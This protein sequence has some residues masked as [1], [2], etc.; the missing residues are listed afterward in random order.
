MK[1]NTIS[2]SSLLLASTTVAG[3]A[4]PS[5]PTISAIS[6]PPVPLKHQAIS[7]DAPSHQ[8]CQDQSCFTPSAF[9]PSTG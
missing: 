8:T 5:L 4:S 6:W 7:E 3:A 9:D 1:L 2:V